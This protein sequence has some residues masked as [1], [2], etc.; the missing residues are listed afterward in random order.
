MNKISKQLLYLLICILTFI[1]L[2]GS[3]INEDMSNCPSGRYLHFE[4]INKKYEFK[5]IVEKVD[6]YI[7]DGEEL[8]DK[9]T[10]SRAEIEASDYKI[11]LDERPNGM[12]LHYIALINEFDDYFRTVDADHKETLQTAIVAAKGD[13]VKNRLPNIFHGAKDILFS[14]KLLGIPDTIYL[15]KNTN[16]INLFVAF[17]GYELPSSSH[18]SSFICGSNGKYNYDNQPIETTTYTY[19]P[20]TAAL[21]SGEYDYNSH[22]TTMRLWIGADT[23]IRLEKKDEVLSPLAPAV[24][25]LHRLNITEELAKVTVNG[26]YIYNTDEKLEAE[27][28]Y[29]ITIILDGNFVVLELV[30]N[31]WVIVRNGVPL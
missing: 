28:E 30:I 21:G 25:T 10:Y 16:D 2:F 13:S 1:I 19:L 18:L 26:E 22:F 4:T 29:D 3:C 7:Y 15:K 27:D 5:D 17:K 12:E 20:Y 11:Y 8:V 24:E 23:D 6:L 31:D 14:N 9:K